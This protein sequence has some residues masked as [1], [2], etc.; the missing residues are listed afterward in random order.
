M[1]WSRTLL[2]QNTP[3]L[4]IRRLELEAW[5]LYICFKTW[6]FYDS[7]KLLLSQKLRSRYSTILILILT[8]FNVLLSVLSPQS[9]SPT[10]TVYI[11]ILLPKQYVKV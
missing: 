3:P 8:L 2:F 9:L 5:I 7:I 11:A 4:V 10:V 1:P 6:G